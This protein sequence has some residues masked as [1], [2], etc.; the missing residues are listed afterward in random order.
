MKAA[1]RVS[2][3]SGLMCAC[4]SALAEP[5]PAR[6]VRLVVATALGSGVDTIARI[7]APRLAEGWGQPVVVDNRTGDGGT[8]GAG[9]V[10]RATSDG[11]TLLAHSSAHIIS[12]SLRASLPYSPLKDFV[13]VAPLTSQAYVMVAGK[14]SGIGSVKDLIAA[15]KTKPGELNF[16]SAGLGTGT[17]LMAEKFNAGAGIRLGHFP[18]AG[19]AAGNEAV[20]SG[21]AT[22]WFSAI[23]PAMPFVRDGRL[24]VLGV[25]SAK[26]LGSMPTV[27]T[28]AEAGLPGYDSTL[29]YGLWAPA[30]TPKAVV[31]T[32]S[33]S[34]QRV[35]TAPEVREQ[36]AKLGAEPMSMT[37]AEFA[38]FVQT[39]AK[40]VAQVVRVAGIKPQ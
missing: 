12:A 15:A 37:A 2:V 16:A 8:A 40:D 21:R 25:S 32:I 22:Y 35:L 18:T 39:E 10:A 17:H 38:R 9:L 5:Y 3:L 24:V 6:P 11:H 1:W 14:Q 26:R 36:L 13:P 7:I 33:R 4:A 34:V 28:V 31:E 27:P 29:W 19:A 20:V 23:T 30:G